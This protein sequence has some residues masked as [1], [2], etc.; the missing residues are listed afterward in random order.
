[1]IIIIIDVPHTQSVIR[2]Y[3]IPMDTFEETDYEPSSSDEESSED[4][5]QD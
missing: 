1:M 5:E 3:S 2:F 4:E